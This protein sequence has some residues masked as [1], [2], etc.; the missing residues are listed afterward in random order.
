MNQHM[1]SMKIV[2]IEINLDTTQFI[3]TIYL[4]WKYAEKT[5]DYYDPR[6]IDELFRVFRQGTNEF[7][8]DL[9]HP[10]FSWEVN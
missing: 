4:T 10:I 2:G 9:K 6:E 5:S 7:M 8:R 1:F 3:T